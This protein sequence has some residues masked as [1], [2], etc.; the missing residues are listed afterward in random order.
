MQAET[1]K[2]INSYRLLTNLSYII[3]TVC[4]S[5][6]SNGELII[7]QNII[8]LKKPHSL[9]ADFEKWRNWPTDHNTVGMQ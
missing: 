8:V 2:R 1:K 6:T 3:I 7:E 4:E 9:M 5:S